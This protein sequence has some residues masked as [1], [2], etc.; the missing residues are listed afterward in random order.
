M[1]DFL[2]FTHISPV[3]DLSYPHYPQIYSHIRCELPATFQKKQIVLYYRQDVRLPK[4]KARSNPQTAAYHKLMCIS[5]GFCM[6]VLLLQNQLSIDTLV[7]PGY[8][9]DHFLPAASGTD[10]K[11]YLYLLRAVSTSASGLSS[12]SISDSLDLTEKEVL[13]SLSY[14]EKVG[15]LRL[16]FTSDHELNGIAFTDPSAASQTRQKAEI[17][18]LT[19]DLPSGPSD[20]AA[21]PARSAAKKSEPPADTVS[22]SPSSMAEQ[23]SRHLSQEEQALLDH[24]PEFEIYMSAWQQYFPQPFNYTDTERISYWYLQFNRSVEII[25]YLVDYCA[26]HGH[27]NTRYLDKTALEWHKRGL[28][29]LAEIRSHNQLV[30]ST[31]YAVMKAYGLYNQQPAPAQ[32]EYIERWINEYGFSDEL[33][34]LACNRTIEKLQR[35]DMKYTEGILQKWKKKNVR[36]RADVEAEDA[37]HAARSKAAAELKSS[38]VSAKGIQQFHNFTERSN[39]KYTDKILKQYSQN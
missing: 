37:L 25:D 16:S 12:A 8:F 3:S 2:V 28:R 33:L 26:S 27:P 6:S 35:P 4:H 24:D 34:I 30:N 32:L 9:V 36:T 19:P 38:P 7:V 18:S 14:W 15:L 22:K 5:G 23:S 29:T 21:V 10:I 31:V 13:R 20:A 1:S 11:V 39:N 17:P